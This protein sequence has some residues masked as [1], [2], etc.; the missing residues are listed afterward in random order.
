VCSF[1]CVR[2]SVCEQ[3]SSSLFFATWSGH[4]IATLGPSG[5]CVAYTYTF[6][7]FVLI[8]AGDV[9][10]FLCPPSSRTWRAEYAAGR[11]P[12]GCWGAGLA[13]MSLVMRRLLGACVSALA[14]AT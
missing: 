11:L 4:C 12:V 10:W 1:V 3:D 2:V 6:L 5:R 13:S 7:L 8:H 14:F 9:L